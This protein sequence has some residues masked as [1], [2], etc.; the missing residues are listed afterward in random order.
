MP[1]SKTRKAAVEKRRATR[2][3]E[4]RKRREE[5]QRAAMPGQRGWVPPLFITVAL[6]GAAWLIVFYVAGYDIPFMAAIGNGN[7]LIGLGAMA[8]AFMLATLWK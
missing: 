1:E 2:L 4:A 5:R 7:L 3:A 6:L 8:V